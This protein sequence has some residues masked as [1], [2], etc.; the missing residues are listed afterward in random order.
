MELLTH[1]QHSSNLAEAIGDELADIDVLRAAGMVG[2]RFPV[3]MAVWRFTELQ[4]RSSLRAAFD[5]LMMLAAKKHLDSDPIHVVS[6]VLQWLVKPVCS[7]CN[8]TAYD[9][10]PGTPHLSDKQCP[11]CSGTGKRPTG[12]G[13]AAKDLYESL[14]EQQRMAAAEIKRKLKKD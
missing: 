13:P 5:G 3:A 4:D 1:A 9:W 12:W 11:V 8:G 7:G 14:L 6:E 10:I 2:Q